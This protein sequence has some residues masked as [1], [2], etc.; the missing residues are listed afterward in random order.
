MTYIWNRSALSRMDIEE[1]DWHDIEQYDA[2]YTFSPNHDTLTVVK[3]KGQPG[4]KW[5]IDLP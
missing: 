1:R 5:V 3:T 2:I 4:K